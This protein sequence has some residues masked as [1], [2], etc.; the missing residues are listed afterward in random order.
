MMR[1]DF[2]V[3]IDGEW[4]ELTPS[5]AGHQMFPRERGFTHRLMDR[6]CT[7]ALVRMGLEPSAALSYRERVNRAA[8]RGAQA[9]L[10]RGAAR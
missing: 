5:E 6:R 8:Y 2:K 3:Q 4:I 1:K 10:Q 9:V 7:A